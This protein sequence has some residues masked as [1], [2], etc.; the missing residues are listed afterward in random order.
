MNPL[1][2]ALGAIGI[3]LAAAGLLGAVLVGGG[4][5]FFVGFMFAAV[6]TGSTFWGVIG[7][8]V[9]VALAL[10]LFFS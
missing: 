3:L 4:F 1:T 2:T 5:F 6:V 10:M 9:A 8:F 7:G